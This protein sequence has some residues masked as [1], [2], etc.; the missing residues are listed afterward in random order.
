[1]KR[2]FELYILYLLYVL[3]LGNAIWAGLAMMAMPDGSALEMTKDV[4]ARTPFK[5]FFLPGLVLFL[6]N[7]IFTLFTLIGLIAKP[8]W[9]WA[10]SINLYKDKHWAWAYSLYAGVIVIA[11]ILVQIT[12]IQFSL[13]QPVIA[14]VGLLILIL[15]L[16][17]RVMRYYTLSYESK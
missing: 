16:L 6:F 2:P 12:M 13:L 10:N 17:P 9:G 1:M 14:G 5:S 4:L 15:T 8:K 11:W 3:L 7:G